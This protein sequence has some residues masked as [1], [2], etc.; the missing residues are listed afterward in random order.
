LR[1]QAGFRVLRRAGDR[2]ESHLIA[3]NHC[4]HRLLACGRVLTFSASLGPGGWRKQ[5]PPAGRN[6]SKTATKLHVR[7][8]T[9]PER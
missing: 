3:P 6:G 9:L 2:P 8:Y 1:Q 5:P 4:V 7:C